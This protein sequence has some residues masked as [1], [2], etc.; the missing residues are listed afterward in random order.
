MPQIIKANLDEMVFEHRERDYGAYVLRKQYPKALFQSF[1][2]GHSP[3]WSTGSYA[4]CGSDV[5]G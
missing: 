5:W 3:I 2:C 4:L 1:S